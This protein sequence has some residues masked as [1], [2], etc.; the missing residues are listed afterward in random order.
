LT[1]AGEQDVVRL[2]VAVD[3][4]G[5]M[6]GGERVGDLHGGVQQPARVAGRSHGRTIHELH[7]QIIGADVVNLADVGMVQGGDGAGLAFE[8]VGEGGLRELDRDRAV[9]TGIA[10]L[11]HL[12]HAARAEGREQFVGSELFTGSH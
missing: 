10:G 9:E 1:L 7:H 8:A 5:L 4:S 6:G 2:E 3:D 12:S 11:P